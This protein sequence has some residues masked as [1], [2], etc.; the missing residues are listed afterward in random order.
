MGMGRLRWAH[1]GL[2]HE[3]TGRDTGL[4]LLPCQ[5]Q[6]CALPLT[7]GTGPSTSCQV[8]GLTRSVP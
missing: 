2:G 4:P 3:G 5:R 1:P 8:R 7:P 6:H